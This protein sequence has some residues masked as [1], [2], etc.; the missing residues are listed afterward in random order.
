MVEVTL[1]AYLTTSVRLSAHLIERLGGE[2]YG[3]P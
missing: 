1:D 2:G 3:I